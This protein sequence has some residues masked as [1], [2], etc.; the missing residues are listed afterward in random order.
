MR[1]SPCDCPHVV[2]YE[3][4]LLDPANGS[5]TR[6]SRRL[7]FGPS[8]GYAAYR[9]LFLRD[10]FQARQWLASWGR[11]CCSLVPSIYTVQIDG[12]GLVHSVKNDVD[13]KLKAG[14]KKER[15]GILVHLNDCGWEL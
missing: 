4:G 8:R 5:G 13:A 9:N 11:I 7:F 1:D 2:P 12:R 14:E 6:V 15:P 3:S 10:S